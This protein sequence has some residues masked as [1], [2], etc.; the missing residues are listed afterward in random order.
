[1]SYNTH[2]HTHSHTEGLCARTGFL[3]KAGAGV[4]VSLNCLA[5]FAANQ[6]QKHA[7]QMKDT[8]ID[9]VQKEEGGK[10]GKER[11]SERGV[12]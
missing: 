2:S 6:R 4:I 10:R 3:A 11:G 12:N 7:S 5:L 1:M 9:R 8:E